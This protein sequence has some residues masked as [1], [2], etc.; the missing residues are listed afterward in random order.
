M[1]GGRS[2]GAAG[3]WASWAVLQIFYGTLE[4]QIISTGVQA[5][6][7][8]V[9]SWRR[10][11]ASGEQKAHTIVSPPAHTKKWPQEVQLE[12]EWVILVIKAGD[13]HGDHRS[14]RC[15]QEEFPAF[16]WCG[17]AT[18]ICTSTHWWSTSLPRGTKKKKKFQQWD[19]LTCYVRPGLIEP[20]WLN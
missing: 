13:G 4:H 16:L 1:K 15:L 17:H 5:G 6:R 7:V 18:L 14:M 9:L 8:W 20:F 3:A 2:Y 10:C 19:G 11:G 12:E